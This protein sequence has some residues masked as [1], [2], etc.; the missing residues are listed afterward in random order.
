MEL[1]NDMPLILSKLNDIRINKKISLEQLSNDIG[2]D[3][4]V[5]SRLLNGKYNMDLETYINICKVLDVDPAQVID[6]VINPKLKRIALDEKD[7]QSFNEIA[8]LIKKY[9]K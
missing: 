4:S 1:F 6:E 5:T 2:K 9:E 7:I 3:K 8:N